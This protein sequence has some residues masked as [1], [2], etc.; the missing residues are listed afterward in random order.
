MDETE[1]RLQRRADE[2]EVGGPGGTLVAFGGVLESVGPWGA[3][4]RGAGG[5]QQTGSTTRPAAT[6]RAR[7]VIAYV[8]PTAARWRRSSASMRSAS[9]SVR[10]S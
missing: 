9:S 1:R 10:W 2:E 3:Y 7:V 8:L 4:Q 5:A 6:R